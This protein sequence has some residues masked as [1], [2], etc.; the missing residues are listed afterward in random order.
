[1]D[2]YS[3]SVNDPVVGLRLRHQFTPSLTFSLSGDVGGFGAGS[4][5][6]WQTL[7]ILNYELYRTSNVSWNAMVGYK[8]LSEPP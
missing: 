3:Q 7:A 6:S 5:F 8:A 1:M 4:K 2:I